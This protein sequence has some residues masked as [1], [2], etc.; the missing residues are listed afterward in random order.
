MTAIERLLGDDAAA[1]K[2]LLGLLF[3][4]PMLIM[5]PTAGTLGDK[6]SATKIMRL[7]RFLEIPW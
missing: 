6:I 2:P 5:A 3:I 1:Y 4:L 7:V